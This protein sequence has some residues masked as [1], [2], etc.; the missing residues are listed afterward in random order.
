MSMKAISAQMVS[1]ASIPLHSRNQSWRTAIDMLNVPGA[2]L[3]QQYNMHSNS[4]HAQ[5]Q[6]SVHHQ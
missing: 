2:A 1:L 3:L 5:I 6:A 4:L